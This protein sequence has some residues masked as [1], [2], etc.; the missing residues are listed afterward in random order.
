M[1]NNHGIVIEKILEMKNFLK[2]DS[3]YKSL[4][5]EEILLYLNDYTVADAEIVVSAALGEINKPKSDYTIKEVLKSPLKGAMMEI[6]DDLTIHT[7][8]KGSKWK[9]LLKNDGLIVA[10]FGITA[11]PH[12]L[13]HAGVNELTGGYNKEIVINS[14]YGGDLW[15]QII[16]N[17]ESKVLF[18]LIGGYVDPEYAS[19]FGELAT[20][21]SPYA[22]TPLGIYLVMKGKE[23]KNVLI[24]SAGAGAV[25]AHLGGVLGDWY[26]TGKAIMTKVAE[27]CYNILGIQEAPE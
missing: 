9:R 1:G 4:L 21:V 11:D 5:T 12:E 23:R 2:R 18:P 25:A 14:L 24:F 26:S 20:K 17:L 7:N 13:L 27:G 19:F 3:F 16:P 10:S 22:L 6:I 15:A 8:L